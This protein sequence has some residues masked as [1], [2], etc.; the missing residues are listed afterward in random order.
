MIYLHLIK[1]VFHTVFHK[2]LTLRDQL[3]CLLFSSWLSDKVPL[4]LTSLE[5]IISATPMQSSKLLGQ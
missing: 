2:S 4:V 5:Q 3:K 1:Y